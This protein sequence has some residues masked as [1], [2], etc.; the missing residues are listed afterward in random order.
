MKDLKETLYLNRGVIY[1]L[2]SCLSNAFSAVI[3]KT[4]GGRIPSMEFVF[5]R[6]LCVIMT[7]SPLLVF[8]DVPMRMTKR[9]FGA[10]IVYVILATITMC[11]R[12]YSLENIPAGDMSAIFSIT[13]VITG[14]LAWLILRERFT[15]VD[16]GLSGIAL[17]GIVLI[18][19]PS[20]LF[21]SLHATSQD[22]NPLLG[23]IFALAGVLAASLTLI[24]LRHMVRTIHPFIQQWWMGIGGC[25][26]VAMVMTVMG[27][28][29]MPRCGYERIVLITQGFAVVLCS[30]LQVFA[31]KI[32]KTSNV[33][34]LGTNSVIFTFILEFA[35]FK[36]PPYWLSVVGAGL[37]VF[38]STAVT[39]NKNRLLKK[40]KYL[41]VTQDD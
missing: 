30:I 7:A 32:V 17:V 27:V 4:L 34:L 40:N 5:C 37:I 36:K 28:W 10:I 11:M 19:R 29:K 6:Q 41:E 18:A 13:P 9:Q 16:A 35:V 12:F 22:G 2:V 39:I 38:S 21:G 26:L 8:Y 20:F 1:I 14:I 25:L 24:L 15:L 3:V 23:A 33:A 31:V